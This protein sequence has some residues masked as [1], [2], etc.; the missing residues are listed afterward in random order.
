MV[1][2]RRVPIDMKSIRTLK[3]NTAAITAKYQSEHVKTTTELTKHKAREE[4]GSKRSLV[5]WVGV[6]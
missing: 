4:R 5:G 1:Y 2:A 3:S 6:G